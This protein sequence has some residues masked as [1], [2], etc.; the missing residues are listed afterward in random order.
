MVNVELYGGRRGYLEHVRTRALYALGAY[1][2]ARNIDWATV[3]R[4]VFVC[5]GNIC[6]SPYASAR[7]RLLGIP[8]ASFGLD[9]AQ[10]APADTTALRTALSRAVDLSAHRSARR[11]SCRITDDDLL[12]VFEPSQLAEIRRWRIDRMPRVTLLGIW[13]QPIRPH[14]QDPYGRSDRYF[15]RCFSIIDASIAEFARRMAG[16]SASSNSVAMRTNG[17]D[18]TLL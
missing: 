10:G 17:P 12:V 18:G 13:A 3:T 5:K 11:E 8:S 7:A 2:S 4:L 16:R 14:I 15:Q 9:A 1:R 6:R